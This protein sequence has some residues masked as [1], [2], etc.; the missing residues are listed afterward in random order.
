LLQDARVNPSDDENL[1]IRSASENGH[2]AVVDRLLQDP[3][4]DPSASKN[5]ALR[6]ANRMVHIPRFKAIVDRL[7]QDSR[8]DGNVIK[9]TT[10]VVDKVDT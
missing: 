4:V 2:L 1:A 8:V 9:P 6:M 5:G 3:R 10:Y 7:L